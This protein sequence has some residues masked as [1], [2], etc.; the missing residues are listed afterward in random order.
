MT[1]LVPWLVFPVVCTCLAIGCALLVERVAGV[2]VS[3]TL[4]LP[5]GIASISLVAGFATL[6]DATAELAV[7][8]VVGLAVL[9]FGLR[10]PR[11]RRV[12]VW[13]CAC[14]VAV[15]VVFGAPVLA[16]GG[17]TFAGY[18]TLDDTST[19]LAIVD[20]TLEHG[21]SLDGLAPSTYEATLDVNL[22]RGYPTGSL[23]PFGVGSRIVGSDPA[24]T[25]Q[26]YMSLL[27]AALGLCLYE[28][29]GVAGLTRRWRAVVGTVAAQP[30]LLYAFAQWGGVKELFAAMLLALL[31][32]TIAVV[33]NAPSRAALVPATAAGALLGGLSLGAVVW[34]AP[35]AAL[36]VVGTL[37]PQWRARALAGVAATAVL[38]V[39]ALAAASQFLRAANRASFADDDELG[40]LTGTLPLRQLLG[41]WPAGDFRADAAEPRATAALLATCALAAVYG[42]LVLGRGRVAA[43]LSYLGASVVGTG[44][45][46]VL[47]SPWLG[48]KALAVGSPAVLF[49]A[50]VAGASVVVAGRR[51]EGALVLSVV[52]AGVAWSNALAFGEARL[53]PRGQLAE[54]ERIGE[55]F[56]GQGPALMTEYQPYGVRHFLR[57]LDAEGS[58][59]LRRR[60][61][62]LRDGRVLGKAEY[63][64]LAAFSPEAVSLYRTLVLRR[65]PP[66][67]RPPPA[68][69]LVWRGR[70]YDVWQRGPYAVQTA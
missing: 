65:A 26:P 5:V 48:A 70:Y 54:L 21:R 44:T 36:V 69:A 34:L 16:S 45:V 64:D 68:Y 47:G 13:A 4:L 62:P 24:W 9:G 28:L 30:A 32:A 17:A 61:I 23:L 51:L 22:A 20:R 66:A 27:A 11:A 19:F 14:A 42:S 39:P 37:R 35:V 12:D 33:R 63:A 56:A 57:R 31:G 7:P 41:I 6:S 53:A 1:L 18:V 15:F 49:A 43:P 29:T 3:G 50:V 58:S 40:N 67:G 8:A 10:R 60:P 55:R 25:F 59:E 2:A 46:L 52:V 38:S